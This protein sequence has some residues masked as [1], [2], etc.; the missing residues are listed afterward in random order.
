MD[1]PLSRPVMVAAIGALAVVIVLVGAQLVRDM[2]RE[3]AELAR[4]QRRREDR[5]IAAERAKA[6]GEEPFLIIGRIF[7]PLGLFA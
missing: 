3:R 5:E 7:D 2:F 4:D 1:L 6:A